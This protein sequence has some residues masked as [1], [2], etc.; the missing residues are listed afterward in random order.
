MERGIS[1]VTVLGE[2]VL[3]AT[4]GKFGETAEAYSRIVEQSS[5]KKRAKLT[6]S[7]PSGLYIAAAANPCVAPLEDRQIGVAGFG[8]V[9]FVFGERG[10]GEPC[11]TLVKELLGLLA[12]LGFGHKVAL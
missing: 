3:S 1:L 11:G 8:D 12:A 7:R 9:V 10:F 4:C 5:K 2:P 6:A